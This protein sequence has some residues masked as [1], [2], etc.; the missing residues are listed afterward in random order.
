MLGFLSKIKNM[1]KKSLHSLF[2][3]VSLFSIFIAFVV[4]SFSPLE[5]TTHAHDYGAH[6]HSHTHTEE[7]IQSHEISKEEESSK[8]SVS[9][10]NNNS[11][12]FAS[13]KYTSEKAFL[14][15]KDAINVLSLEIG[16]L[17]KKLLYIQHNV[18]RA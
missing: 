10:Q 7:I 11:P 15:S 6:S 4:T 17:D 13:S 14:D 5:I 16:S 12:Y 3:N 1:P 9:A 2:M 18:I 8:E